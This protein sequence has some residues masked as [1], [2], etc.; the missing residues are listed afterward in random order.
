M[1]EIDGQ[2]QAVVYTCSCGDEGGITNPRCCDADGA[3]LPCIA[4]RV[5]V[6]DDASRITSMSSHFITR[7]G[8]GRLALIGYKR[9]APHPIVATRS[10]HTFSQELSRSTHCEI[11][12]HKVIYFHKRNWFFLFFWPLRRPAPATPTCG[13]L[14]PTPYTFSITNNQT[15]LRSQCLSQSYPCKLSLTIR[16]PSPHP[17]TFTTV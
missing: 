14:H 15:K 5:G 11:D 1:K 3:T 2:S 10:R 7:S 17:A 4:S 8:T 13:S 16:K 12:F 6:V 9:S